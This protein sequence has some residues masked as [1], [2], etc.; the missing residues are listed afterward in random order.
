MKSIHK[1]SSWRP[2]PQHRIPPAPLK[3][4]WTPWS[5]GAA[6]TEMVKGCER[7]WKGQVQCHFSLPNSGANAKDSK[8]VKALA[9][10]FC[11][12]S[13]SKDYLAMFDSGNPKKV[14]KKTNTAQ[15]AAI[16]DLV[17]RCTLKTILVIGDRHASPYYQISSAILGVAYPQVMKHANGN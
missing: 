2:G 1:S 13:L 7:M 6:W 8:L 11:T 4:L 15:T 3:R 14:G 5:L 17:G 10:I 16:S 12:H 9:S